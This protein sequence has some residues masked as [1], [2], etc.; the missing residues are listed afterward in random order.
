MAKLVAF[1]YVSLDGY[2]AGPRGEI[3]WF[4]AIGKDDEYESYT[5]R[6]SS[7]GGALIFG[8]TTYEM[9]KSYWPT[10]P[11]RKADPEM[12][13]AVNEN[14]KIVFSKKLNEADE[15][16]HWK[17]VTLLHDIEASDIRKRKGAATKGFTILGSGSIVRQLARLGLVDEYSLVV[18]PLLLGAGKP[19]FDDFE[20]TRLELAESKSFRN[21]LLVLRYRPA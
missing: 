7:S 2:F 4:K 19:L 14:P 13:A 16:P 21:G 9:M 15:G 5:H 6:Q 3:D 17:N 18:V 11:A 20:K 1:T 10:A 12:A 8:R